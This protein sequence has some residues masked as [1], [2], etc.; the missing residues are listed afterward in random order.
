M[1]VL[2][3]LKQGMFLSADSLV[4][5]QDRLRV[6]WLHDLLYIL[7]SASSYDTVKEAM[8]HSFTLIVLVCMMLNMAGS[9]TT[10]LAS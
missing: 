5:S 2:L 6:E 3:P 4:V 1:K 10:A 7:D 8:K 9:E